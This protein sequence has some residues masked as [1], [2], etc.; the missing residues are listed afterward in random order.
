M[1]SFEDRAPVSARRGKSGGD[2]LESGVTSRLSRIDTLLSVH[3]VQ[4]P[5]PMKGSGETDQWREIYRFEGGVGWLAHPDERMQRASH[6]LVARH[7]SGHSETLEGNKPDSGEN[8]ESGINTVEGNNTATDNSPS[9]DSDTFEGTSGGADSGGQ[10]VVSDA[11]VWVVDPVDVNGLD[12]ML[13][14]LGRVRGVVLLL[15]RHTRD[16]AAVANRHDVPVWI[17][18]FFDGVAG[19]LE[20][21]VERFRHDLAD[22]GFAVHEVIDSRFWQEALLFDRERGIMAVPEAVGTAEY[23]LAGDERLGVHPM[24]RLK[25]PS[26]LMRL[27]PEHVLVGHGEGIHSNATDALEDAIQGSQSRTPALVA[28]NA[29]ALLPL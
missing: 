19:E 18:E 27:D 2:Q 14:E 21:P 28:K 5:M 12:E 24:L 11:D 1:Q 22:S 3:T 23:F 10:D 13:A 7:G 6:A 15:D 29:R 25:P 20:A 17:P 4:F 9:Q 26:G 16:S 8:G